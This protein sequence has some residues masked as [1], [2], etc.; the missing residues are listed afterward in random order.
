M[1]FIHCMYYD[2]YVFICEKKAYLVF[3]SKGVGTPKICMRRM[4]IANL[5]KKLRFRPL[6]SLFTKRTQKNIE[7]RVTAPEILNSAID[8][9]V[10]GG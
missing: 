8:R 4:V 2:V 1:Q 9:G 10:W 7:E 3:F 5:R 6:N